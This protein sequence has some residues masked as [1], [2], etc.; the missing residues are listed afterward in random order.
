M[1]LRH[2]I[3]LMFL[4]VI[5][6]ILFRDYT[7]SN[8]LRYLNIADEAIANGNIFAFYDHGVPYADKPPLYLWIVML[9]KVLFGEHIMLFLAL[10]SVLPAL[11]T[12]LVMNKFTSNYLKDEEQKAATLM[13]FTSAFFLACSIVL[14]MDML[15]T[16]FIVLSLY[17]FFRMYESYK[18]NQEPKL[19]TKILLP[20]IGRASCRERVYVLV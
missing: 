6:L 2:I 5:P 14:R 20:E 18:D 12:I 9:G 8:E 3:I 16:M 13:L 1:K 17:T 7:P 19:R 4:S 11:V 15:M 10:F